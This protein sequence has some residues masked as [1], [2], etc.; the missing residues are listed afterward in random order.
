M[1]EKII[2]PGIHDHIPPQGRV[3]VQLLNPD[4]DKVVHEV[5]AEN[6]IMDWFLSQVT[7]SRGDFTT[8][9]DI[10][11]THTPNL[12]PISGLTETIN[13][14]SPVTVNMNKPGVYPGL[15][16][17]GPE[18]AWIWGSSAN[19]SPN[20]AHTHIP[21]SDAEGMMTG[22]ARLDVAYTPD[23][24]N[25]PRGT[26]V[27]SLCRHTWDKTR[28][29]V[30]FSTAQG[31][32]VYRSIGTG[33]LAQRN[34]ATLSGG[35]AAHPASLWY[36]MQIRSAVT[37][38][39]HIS[40][41]RYGS[42]NTHTGATWPDHRCFVVEGDVTTTSNA[43]WIYDF[44]A[45]AVGN[46]AGPTSNTI[47]GSGRISVA[48][49]GGSLWIGRGT[50]LKR[51]DYPTDTSLNVLNTYS[52]VTGFT[53]AAI[54]DI[55]S[56]G[57]NIYALGSTKVFI[58]NPATGAVTSSWT[59]SLPRSFGTVGNIEWDPAMQMLWLTTETHGAGQAYI[60]WGP[61]NLPNISNL[62][63]P[64]TARSYGYTIA[65]TRL[66]YAI[67]FTTPQFGVDIDTQTLT[68]NAWDGSSVSRFETGVTGMAQQN[69]W[70]SIV[71]SIITAVTSGTGAHGLNHRGPSMSSHAL[72][73]SDVTKTSANTLR[74]I[75]DFDWS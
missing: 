55:T 11:K 41:F 45:V 54:I 2:V 72:L 74:I 14:R 6:A 69:G 35:G 18:C 43:I 62:C 65:G 51:C 34:I 1:K 3:T 23:P 52:P 27:S 42:S 38:N 32:G 67:P 24:N 70:T 73:P 20:A 53:D 17:A 21:G 39:T 66:N 31:N 64:N 37:T 63:N 56:D 28:M 50:T 25:L 13:Q 44:S 61:A 36:P 47:G 22:F 30:E 49:H 59:H 5:K 19:I 33:S 68:A 46:T 40:Y 9:G 7:M 71:G 26:V 10:R 4:T 60:P 12:S 16:S 29:T 58:I 48:T 75:Y 8:V 15:Y 57:T